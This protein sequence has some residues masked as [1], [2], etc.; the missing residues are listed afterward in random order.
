[1]KL[2]GIAPCY[3]EVEKGNLDRFLENIPKVVDGLVLLDD[4][5]TDGS[6]ERMLEH[7]PHVLKNKR[8]M[9]HYEQFNTKQL[10]QLALKV[11]PDLTHIL[12]LNIDSTFTP[13]CYKDGEALIH[14]ACHE[15]SDTFEMFYMRNINLW[16]SKCWWRA[17]HLWRFEEAE[18]VY[19]KD[20]GLSL[21]H[22]I[23][24]GLHKGKTTAE[25]DNSFC[26]TRAKGYDSAVSLHWGFTN[27]QKIVDKFH[28]YLSIEYRKVPCPLGFRVTNVYKMI[29]EFE[30]DFRPVDLSWLEGDLVTEALEDLRR[31][32]PI[33]YH[34]ELERY[35]VAKASCYKAHFETVYGERYKSVEYSDK[36]KYSLPKEAREEEQ[37]WEKSLQK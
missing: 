14:K 3:N 16:R 30:V 22:G 15:F 11:Y 35:D 33:S 6:Y 4:A 29:E 12:T 8:N 23:K 7:T 25:Y 2:I 9:F 34:K 5:S 20:K 27:K 10:I 21:T 18:R 17:D 37:I 36:V 28:R 26:I 32:Q 1:M 24:K 13:S 31:P 19:I